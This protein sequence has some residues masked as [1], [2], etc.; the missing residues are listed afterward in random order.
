MWL[1]AWFSD[2]VGDGRDISRQGELPR[3]FEQRSYDDYNTYK[4]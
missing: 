3:N 4:K 2:K 1:D